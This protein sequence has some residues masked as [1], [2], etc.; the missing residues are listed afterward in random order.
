MV[1]LKEFLRTQFAKRPGYNQDKLASDI[2]M[3]PSTLTG[4]LQRN[5]ITVAKLEMI[6]AVMKIDVRDFFA[7]ADRQDLDINNKASELT[8]CQ[9]KLDAALK[10]IELLEKLVAQY[11]KQLL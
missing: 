2:G 1:N 8:I 7:E 6:A 3:A 10:Q 4:I 9:I 5:D 11:E